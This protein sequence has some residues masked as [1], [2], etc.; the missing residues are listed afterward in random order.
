MKSISIFT[1]VLSLLCSASIARSQTNEVA[2]EASFSS[3]ANNNKITET[4]KGKSSL[5]PS[6]E[7]SR[8]TNLN[9]LI[10]LNRAKNIARQ[11]AEQANGGLRLYRAELSM[12]EA[13]EDSPHKINNDG[14]LTFE[15]KG[16][17]ANESVFTIFSVVTVDLDRQ[18]ATVNYNGPIKTQVQ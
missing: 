7:N 12:Y 11:A 2:S 5:T 17:A 4:D 15:F 16:R 9:N 3:K 14:T 10:K 18:T 6:P 1:I 13:G 8:E